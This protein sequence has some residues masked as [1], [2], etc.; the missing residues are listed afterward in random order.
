MVRRAPSQSGGE[1][2]TEASGVQAG[3]GE[4]RAGTSD[5]ARRRVRGQLWAELMRRTFGFDVPSCPRCGGRLHLSALIE[6]AAVVQRMLGHLGLPTEVP[7]PRPARASP[8]PIDRDASP[9]ADDL[10]GLDP[11]LV[12]A[13]QPVTK[14]E[15]C[16]ACGRRPRCRAIGARL[17][18]HSGRNRTI[19]GAVSLWGAR[20]SALFPGGA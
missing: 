1:A 14:P 16:R 13:T 2:R 11:L 8:L 19:I 15:V 12:I 3:Q 17:H 6:Q 10:A 4:P 9:L 7:V 20:Q 18:C 5:A